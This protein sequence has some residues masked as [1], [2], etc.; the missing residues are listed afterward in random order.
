LKAF[1]KTIGPEVVVDTGIVLEYLNGS[2]AGK[3]IQEL[4][5]SNQFIISIL[6]TPVL[7]IEMY[8]LLRRKSGKDFVLKILQKLDAILSFV[9][10]NDYLSQCGE[11]K[12]T[13]PFALSD[14]CTLGLAAHKDLKALFL[15]ER[16]IDDQLYEAGSDNYTQRIV[17][18]DDFQAFKIQE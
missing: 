12:A 4:V 15:H 16:E 10:L 5:F 3:K 2:S 11:I 9:P 8:Y 17:F 18:I 14:C 6:A 7:A 1:N 13:H